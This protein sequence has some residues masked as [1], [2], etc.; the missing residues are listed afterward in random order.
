MSVLS[1]HLRGGPAA[2]EFIFLLLS[3]FPFRGHI[4]F[5]ILDF[6]SIMNDIVSMGGFCSMGYAST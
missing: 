2:C 6:S 1:R 5:A 4:I 3:L